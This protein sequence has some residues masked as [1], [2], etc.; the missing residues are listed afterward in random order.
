MMPSLKADEGAKELLAGVAKGVSRLQEI[1]NDM[2]SVIRVE[3]ADQSIK[4]APVSIRSVIK[5]VEIEHTNK[6]GDR[7]LTIETDIAKDLPMISGDAK[8]LHSALSRI[9]GNAVKYTPDDGRIT[10]S[11]YLLENNADDSQSFVQIVVTDTGVGIDMEKQ[12]L[13][14]E[15]FST[16]EDVA[17]HSTSK[18]NFMGGG[19]G[20]GLTIAKGV[21]SAHDGRIWVESEGFDQE[22]LPGSKFFILLPTQ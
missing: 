1:M 18:T 2:V 21:I 7:Q 5:G 13:I 11:A 12:K 17:L 20:L 3:L 4:F 19:A 16:A 10:I 6:M 9:V 8:Q 14:F 15:K 22:R